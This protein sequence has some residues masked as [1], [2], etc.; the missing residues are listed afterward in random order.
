MSHVV[1][2]L[3][4]VTLDWVNHVY[5][6]LSYAPWMYLFYVFLMFTIVC[7]FDVLFI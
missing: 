3:V 5:W 2:V 1:T 4:D 6:S 7:T